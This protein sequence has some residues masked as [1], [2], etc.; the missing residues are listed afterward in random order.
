M[1]SNISQDNFGYKSGFIQSLKDGAKIC[2]YEFSMSRILVI[3]TAVLTLFISLCFM[4]NE[5]TQT[6]IKTT[7][8]ALIFFSFL[9]FLVSYF[10]SIA[11]SF[12]QG[13]FG[14]TAY[15]THSLPISLD[16]MLL[17]KTLIFVL[18]ALVFFLELVFLDVATGGRVLISVVETYEV[19]G[20][21]SS[22]AMYSYLVCFWL[23]CLLAEIMYIFMIATLVHRKKTYVFVWGIMY[24]F[25][26]KI[27]L[28]II[29]SLVA[30]NL[31]DSF[32]MWLSEPT[33]LV[34]HLALVSII[35][36]VFFALVFYFICRKIIRDNLSI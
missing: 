27:A 9:I 19:I 28:S 11:I 30:I 34:W 12:Y 1:E 15:L 21:A 35:P 2:K 33:D 7:I 10:L 6:A 16:A 32:Y 3:I 22:T 17:G 20:V 8:G 26:L 31:P 5:N 14:R 24:Y 23:S 18:W 36:P 29:T 4:M 25:A 13:I